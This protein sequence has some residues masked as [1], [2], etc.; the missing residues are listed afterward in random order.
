MTFLLAH[1]SDAHIGPL[2]R[3]K[4]SELLGKRLTGYLNWTRGRSR[5]HDMEVLGRIVDDMRRRRP[6]HVAMTGDVLNLG[7][8]AEFEVA[9]RWVSSLGPPDQVSFTPGNH[10]AYISGIMPQL[11]ECFAPW[12]CGD[13]SVEPS[14]PYFRV[15]GQVA[16][17]G[18]SS[19]EPTPPFLATGRLGL[20]Q[21]LAF[22][23]ALDLANAQSL[24][25]VVLIHH[26]PHR[27]GARPGRNL[28]DAGGFEKIIAQCGAE[29]ILHGHNHR[30]S[31]AFLTGPLGPVPVVG[32][33]SASAVPGTDG[34]RASYH[35]FR[36][37]GSARRA[38]IEGVVRGFA[39]GSDE[40]TDIGR[41]PLGR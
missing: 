25:R 18:L 13:R 2:P 1:L 10:D 38:E 31:V 39:P 20:V 22:V 14:F 35:L 36:I 11:R 5:L 27:G 21:R 7:L 24:I 6:D 26:P 17:I 41:L 29:L 4:P 12:T 16:L 33:A 15:R 30:R 40:I 3:P 32:V 37:G 23:R 9:R 8:P 19:G 28:T 34:H